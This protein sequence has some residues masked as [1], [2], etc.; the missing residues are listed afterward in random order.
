MPENLARCSWAVNE[1]LIQY[2]DTEYGELTPSDD[3]IFEKICLESFSA[4]LSWLIVLKK[5][6]ALRSAFENFVLERC[7]N[8]TDAA[9]EDAKGNPDIIRNTRKIE[10][11]RSNARACLDIRDQYG[12][13][14]T[15]VQSCPDMYKLAS[16]MRGFG[17][18]QFGPICAQELRKSLGLDPAHEAGC[19]KAVHVL[20]D[21]CLNAFSEQRDD[22]CLHS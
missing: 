6:E 11:V 1:L 5:R 13:L 3:A 16:A 4:G 14:L 7:A 15:F 2:H 12:S 19:F 18:R 21:S 22:S 10:A 9:L 20:P 17:V 8:L